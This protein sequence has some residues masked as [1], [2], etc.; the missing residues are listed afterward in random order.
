MKHDDISPAHFR[1]DMVKKWQGIEESSGNPLAIQFFVPV[2]RG[3]DLGTI[4][5]TK[6]FHGQNQFLRSTKM[7]LVHNL[8][9][10]DEVLDLELNEHIDISEEYLALRNILRSFKVKGSPV[11]LS[12]ENTYTLG[13][14]RFYMRKP[15]RNIPSTC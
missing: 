12:V 9:D 6:I 14:Y 13:T 5:M 8:V 10:M 2:G 11:I 3:A 1:E 7:K 4:A 15:W